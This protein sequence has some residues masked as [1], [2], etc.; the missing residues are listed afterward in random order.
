[1]NRIGGSTEAL[2]NIT[3]RMGL[4]MIVKFHNK[5]LKLPMPV[6]IWMGVLAGFNGMGPLFFPGHREAWV[7]L[8]VFLVSAAIMM[9][10]AEFAGFTR[11]MGAG[12]VLWIPLLVY[13]WARMGAYPAVEPF[14]AWMRLVMLLNAASLVFDGVDMT[15]Y[16]RGE[17]DELV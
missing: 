14:G 4:Q 12:H 13:L 3:G 1:M 5:F 7:V 2:A 9:M 17:R 15:R 10:I 6:V 8:V 11:L 16:V